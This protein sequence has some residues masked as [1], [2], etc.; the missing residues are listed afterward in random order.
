MDV[1]TNLVNEFERFRKRCIELEEKNKKDETRCLMLENEVEILR[2]RNEELERKIVMIQN[3][4][5][6]GDWELEEN[7][8]FV[9]LMIE[10]KVLECEKRKAE[11][12]LCT[13]KEKVKKLEARVSELEANLNE[14][15]MEEDV[16]NVVM[17]KRTND[18]FH[19]KV[20]K[21]LSFE[22][23]T[24]G[25]GSNK[26]IAPSTP[27][28]GWT[29]FSG[30]I[31]ISDEE[32]VNEFKGGLLSTKSG[33]RETADK[34]VVGGNDENSKT[35]KGHK[36]SFVVGLS[37]TGSA[38][39]ERGVKVV[40][41]DDVNGELDDEDM[42]NFEVR[43]S[44]TKSGKRKRATK[45]VTSD[46]ED[47]GYDDNAL[48]C[49]LIKTPHSSK[50]RADSEG[51]VKEESSKKRLTRLRNLKS[52]NIQDASGF[53]LKENVC[54][55]GNVSSEEESESEGES[56]D[57]FIVESS[58]NESVSDSD[59]GSDYSYDQ[60]EDGLDDFKETLKKI[61]R[62]KGSN[63][64]WDLEGDMLADFGKDPKL[65][66]RA[67][68]VLYRQQTA[69]EKA[70]KG[71]FHHNARGFSQTDAFRAS[72]LAEFLTDGDSAGDLNKTVQ[73]LK[74]YDSKGIPLCMELAAKY[75]KQLFQ[76]YKN[77]E[78]RYFRPQ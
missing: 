61:G 30:V 33:E 59:S 24:E 73:Q 41:S 68:C 25:C 23:E 50:L 29:P 8:K 54:L 19:G 17:L 16:N 7:D 65:C 56:L 78:D 46:D 9:Q 76:I 15:V 18:G 32:D 12:D 64:N 21:R 5:N 39:R 3:V 47:D 10:N 45:I 53:D 27:G 42:D 49:T 55:H 14:K 52:E 69:D 6:D 37:N 60:S 48:I 62:K 75:S 67:V 51:E 38:K 58:E 4:V 71:T 40:T 20:R 36:G 11:T 77:K 57:G 44:N 35:D 72:K 63:L 66:M 28:E 26:K 43:S 31:D 22:E 34:I 1:E 74:R 13:C 70:S 2:K